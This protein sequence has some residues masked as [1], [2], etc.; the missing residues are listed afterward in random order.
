M[1]ML[2][3]LCYPYMDVLVRKQGGT[4]EVGLSSLGKL[5]FSSIARGAI[6]GG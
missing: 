1:W 5:L 2:E 4:Y 3:E 6:Y